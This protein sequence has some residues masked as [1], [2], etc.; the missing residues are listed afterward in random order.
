MMEDTFLTYLHCS[1]DFLNLNNIPGLEVG[2]H[3]DSVLNSLP[4]LYFSIIL[5]SFAVAFWGYFGFQ[6]I[7]GDD[8]VQICSYLN[9]EEPM[10]KP[11]DSSEDK[12]TELHEDYE[13]S[14]TLNCDALGREYITDDLSSVNLD[15]LA[16]GRGSLLSRVKKARQKAIRNAVEKDMTEDERQREQRAASEMLARVYSVMKENEEVFGTTSFDDVK[17]QMD[18]YN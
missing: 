14:D 2:G 12:A 13:N 4:F 15:D 18:L 10:N 9:T 5:L 3:L 11:I 8:K 17:S 6:K 16:E 1:L 7:S